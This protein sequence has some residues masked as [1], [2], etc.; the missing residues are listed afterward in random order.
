MEGRAE[1]KCSYILVLHTP[2][3]GVWEK[4]FTPDSKFKA[5]EVSGLENLC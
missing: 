2:Q 4:K 1:N 3:C 5:E